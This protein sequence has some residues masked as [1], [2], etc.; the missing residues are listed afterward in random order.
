MLSPEEESDRHAVQLFSSQA[1][2]LTIQEG[3]VTSLLRGKSFGSLPVEIFQEIIRLA[4]GDPAYPMKIRIVQLILVC[5]SWKEGITN[6]GS[7]YTEVNYSVPEPPWTLALQ[8]AGSSWISFIFDT[9]TTDYK[10]LDRF[11]QLV[12]DNMDRCYLL[13]LRFSAIPEG[14]AKKL[15][16]AIL[17][18]PAPVLQTFRIIIPGKSNASA[19]QPRDRMLDISASLVPWNSGLLQ[20]LTSL[21]IHRSSWEYVAPENNISMD[22][23]VHVIRNT[24]GLCDLRLQNLSLTPWSDEK[25]STPL[26]LP[27]LSRVVVGRL[28]CDFIS[29]FLI[30]LRAPNCISLSVECDMGISTIDALLDPASESLNNLLASLADADMLS[31]NIGN[32]SM[33]FNSLGS[34]R[35]FR[36]ELWNISSRKAAFRRFLSFY[37]PTTLQNIKDLALSIHRRSPGILSILEHALP[38]IETLVVQRIHQEGWGE[39]MEFLSR[40]KGPQ[41]WPLLDDVTVFAGHPS[42]WRFLPDQFL[43]FFRARVE[44]ID[45]VLKRKFGK[46][47]V[48]GW[49]DASFDEKVWEEL[50][51]LVNDLDMP[52]RLGYLSCTP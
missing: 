17:H 19:T 52:K 44:L 35:H 26:T 16:K 2:D 29:H 30:L 20:R 40:P 9:A 51:T 36:F 5:R 42:G 3:P 10:D 43:R 34:H 25:P 8:K 50:R 21:A 18:Y 49:F 1:A 14:D 47:Y 46:V 22:H 27:D 12:L 28:H 45:H 33:S 48:R 24:P 38:S 6:Y 41:C 31:M 32:V 15:V 37:Q 39:L 23:L 4:L 7:F 13:V 11:L